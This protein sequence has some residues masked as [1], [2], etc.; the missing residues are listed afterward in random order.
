MRGFITSTVL[1][2]SIGLAG[3]VMTPVSESV[4]EVARSA[5][6]R[7]VV[8]PPPDALGRQLHDA[9]HSMD[10]RLMGEIRASVPKF[11]D[12]NNRQ[13]MRHMHAMGPNYTWYI[14][15]ENARGGYGVLILAHGF[16]EHGDRV[17]GQRVQSIADQHPTALAMG[18]SMMT[19]DHIQLAINNLA[20]AGVDDIIV[21]PAVSTRYNTM[22]RQWDY[23]F[24]LQAEPE[25]AT[26]ERVNP[27]VNLYIVSPLED[28]P[29]VGDTLL[30]YA[31]EI[32]KNPAQ[33]DVIIVAHGPVFAADNEAQLAMLQRLADY[34]EPRSDYAS[35]SVAT[36]Q[37]DAIPAV[38][39]ANVAVL[40]ARVSESAAAGRDVLIITNLLGTRMVQSSLRRDLRGLEYRFNRKGLIQHDNFIRWI[41]QSVAGVSAGL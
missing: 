3:C 8:A 1:G 39:E 33:E 21:V 15:P 19:S 35:I 7:L 41:E 6:P 16:R 40:R 38:R 28:N 37:D 24:G 34:M 20:A 4:T 12:L 14:S 31:A 23:I 27:P 2:V 18:M 36:L 26:V 17:F 13:I 25:Y 29:L 11:A 5:E 9:P 10:P 22:L 32:S 30:E